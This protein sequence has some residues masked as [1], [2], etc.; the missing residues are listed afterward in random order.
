MIL[1]L[2]TSA[3]VKLYVAEP[4]S[5]DVKAKVEAT[6]VIAVSRVAYV[7]ARAGLARKV[8]EGEISREEYRRV[9]K[10]L[11]RDWGKY[12]IVEVSESV[13]KL[14]G[15]LTDTH[16]LKGFDALHLAS[17]L[18]LKSRTHEE[19][20]FFCFDEKLKSAA[21]AEGLSVEYS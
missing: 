21:E 6:L 15:E 2:D 17:A 14:G 8:R 7:E 1:Y 11:D 9:V 13:A 12:C 3:L 20:L 4:G 5:D 16:P 19:I 10:D 18:F